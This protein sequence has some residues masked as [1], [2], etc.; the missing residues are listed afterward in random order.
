LS[1]LLHSKTSFQ[2]IRA[3]IWHYSCLWKAGTAEMVL[4]C[5][6][7]MQSTTWY[8]IMCICTCEVYWSTNI[9]TGN[10]FAVSCRFRKSD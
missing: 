8:L 6:T 1:S 5:T 7:T 2:V 9:L 4:Y 10:Q 3:N